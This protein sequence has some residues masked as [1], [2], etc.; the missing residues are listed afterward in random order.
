[1]SGVYT[2]RLLTMANTAITQV[3]TVPVGAAWVLKYITVGPRS[4]K[5]GDSVFIVVTPGVA[6]WGYRLGADLTSAQ[7]W[8]GTVAMK[9]G[10][11]LS[12]GG[13]S[14]NWDVTITGYQ[15]SV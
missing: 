1:M 14:G 12:A 4:Q 7:Y 6:I 11:Q 13:G 5:A 9:A 3:A 8:S 2:V 10:E 15:F